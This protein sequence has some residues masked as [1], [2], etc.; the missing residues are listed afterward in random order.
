[1]RSAQDLVVRVVEQQTRAVRDELQSALAAFREPVAGSPR[2]RDV[3]WAARGSDQRRDFLF[4]LWEMGLAE[5]AELWRVVEEHAAGLVVLLRHDKLLPIPMLSLGR[6]IQE[7]LLEV[8]WALDPAVDAAVRASRCAALMLRTIQ[9]NVAPLSQIPNG[10][11][12]LADVRD[13]MSQMNTLLAGDQVDLR[14]DKSGEF[15][16]SVAYEGSARA[17]LKINI[18]EAA[19]KYM[20]GSEHM[21]SLGSGATHSRNWFTGGLEGPTDLFYIMIAT[22]LLDFTDAV[23]DNTHGLVGLSTAE[24]HNRAHERRVALLRRRPGYDG[25]RAQAGYREYAAARVKSDLNGD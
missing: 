13:A 17:P 22:P 15:A 7:A 20:P 11:E 8:C 24:F 21:W 16:T 2:E 10:A 5:V 23:I 4:G 25:S 12:K 19:T 1:M 6:S 18:T 9:G 3:E 14:F